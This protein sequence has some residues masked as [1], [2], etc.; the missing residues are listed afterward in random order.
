MALHD[1]VV[2]RLS[3]GDVMVSRYTAGAGSVATMV[4]PGWAPKGGMGTVKR[5]V[6]VAMVCGLSLFFSFL[7]SFFLLS[8][9]FDSLV[10]CFIMYFLLLCCC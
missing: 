5:G 8:F 4:P 9:L 1:T 3:A 6:V 7:F 2:S 10:V